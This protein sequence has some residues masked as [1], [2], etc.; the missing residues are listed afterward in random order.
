MSI[1]WFK[2]KLVVSPGFRKCYSHFH[3][4]IVRRWVLLENGPAAMFLNLHVIFKWHGNRVKPVTAKGLN[5]WINP[6]DTMSL[7][8]SKPTQWPL[9]R[10]Q[11]ALSLG[12][13]E[14]RNVQVVFL[15]WSVHYV[16]LFFCCCCCLVC[17]A[18]LFRL[19]TPSLQKWSPQ[20]ITVNVLCSLIF[21]YSLRFSDQ[22][23]EQCWIM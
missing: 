4:R 18:G 16:F 17:E 10:T 15:C 9:A 11:G 7:W 8:N 12:F 13:E 21:T 23:Q 14:L 1:Y 3:T 5:S 22:L 6:A 20:D 19:H 2:I